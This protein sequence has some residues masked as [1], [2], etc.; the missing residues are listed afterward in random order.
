M[1][2]SYLIDVALRVV[3]AHGNGIVTDEDLIQ[4]NESLK[5]DPNFDPTFNQLQDFTEVTS[6]DVKNETIIKIVNNRF[7]D[8]SSLRAIVVNPGLQYGLARMFQNL[9]SPEDTNISV[10]VD[11]AE[12]KQWLGLDG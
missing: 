2:I 10:F 1:P 7:F 9:R 4:F 8:L 3:I 5:A 6:V 11:L 12:A